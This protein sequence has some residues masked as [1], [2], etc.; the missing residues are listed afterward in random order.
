M[1]MLNVPATVGLIVLATP[2]V[3]LIFERSAF[4]AADTAATAAA[5]QFYALGLVGYSIVR[6]ASPVFYALGQN[7]TPVAI[8]VATVVV[9]AALNIALVQVL[10]Y[11]GLALGTSVAAL[12]NAGCL[13][14]FLR[15]HL[16]GI[17]GRR[18]SGSLVRVAVASAL[19]GA[20][21][22]AADALGRQWLPGAGLVQQLG[23]LT[24]AMIAALGVLA[25]AA[26]V[27]RIREFR[28]GVAIVARR[29]RR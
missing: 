12:F 29:L 7:R 3:R 20:A 14:F 11:R 5:L 17:D 18:V 24:L 15:R 2:I 19:M 25:A 6:I 27:L 1:L 28:D 26:H 4:T 8:S 23:R 9:N 22:L 13:M 10:G 16:E 21:A